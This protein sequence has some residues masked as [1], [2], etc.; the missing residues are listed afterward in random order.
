MEAATG[1]VSRDTDRGKNKGNRGLATYVKIDE[2]IPNPC[3][4]RK[5]YRDEKLREL[6]ESIRVHGLIQPL[7]VVKKGDK[8]QLVVGERRWRA[9][10]EAGIREVPVILEDVD[11]KQGLE[12]ALVEN[13][14][15]ED[16]NPMEEARAYLFLIEEHHY[17]QEMLSQRIGK[18]RPSVANAL[19]LLN[20]PTEIQNDIAGGVLSQGHGRAL[21]S[22]ENDA[23]QRLVWERIKRRHLSVRQTEELVRDLKIIDEKPTEKVLHEVTDVEQRLRFALGARVTVREN[24]KGRGKIEI[25]FLSRQDFERL[26]ES[27]ILNIPPVKKSMDSL[28]SSLL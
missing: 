26:A 11:E 22:I 21:C 2:I 5:T 19:R 14:H 25:H 1:K 27:L 16:L 20:L 9:A 18:S 24:K 15:R 28:E 6:E 23:V 17:S 10:K 7:V 4:P 3:Q 12:V 8:Y 13:L